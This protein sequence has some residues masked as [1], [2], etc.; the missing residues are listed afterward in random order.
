MEVTEYKLLIIYEAKK[1]YGRVDEDMVQEGYLVFLEVEK[2]FDKARGVPFNAYLAQQLRFHFLE[3]VRKKQ[4][5][6]S[7][8]TR[9]GTENSTLEQFIPAKEN[10]EEEVETNQLEAQIKNAINQLSNKQRIIIHEIFFNNK[11]LPQI[12]NE[13][14]ISYETAKTHKKR[15]MKKLRELIS[16][17]GNMLNRP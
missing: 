17:D 11:K 16:K 1:I 13:M 15:A 2:K 5:A 3:Q 8:Q 14:Q 9:V 7:M 12:A 6:I 10:T 4:P